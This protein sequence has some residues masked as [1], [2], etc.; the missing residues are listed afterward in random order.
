[1]RNTLITIA[2]LIG[3]LLTFTSCTQEG[4]SGVGLQII[5]EGQKITIISVVP[6]SP[7]ARAGIVP[8]LVILKVDD[9]T[10]DGKDQEECAQMI[11]GPVGSKVRLELFDPTNS[12]TTTFELTKEIIPE[13]Q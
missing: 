6:D 9:K 1:M 3:L 2:V 8:G 4:L 11:R 13:V 7:A 12:K 5:D 10:T